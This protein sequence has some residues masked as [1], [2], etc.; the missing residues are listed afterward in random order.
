MKLN[1][2]TE[3]VRE[4]LDARNLP[5]GECEIEALAADIL[6]RLDDYTLVYTQSVGAFEIFQS[7]AADERDAFDAAVAAAIEARELSAG[8]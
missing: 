7:G 4:L 8:N 3:N 5:S 6:R 1:M 2:S